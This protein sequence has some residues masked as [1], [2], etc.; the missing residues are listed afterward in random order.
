[1]NKSLTLGAVAALLMAGSQQVAAQ[2]SNFCHLQVVSDIEATPGY[3][4]TLWSPFGTATLSHFSFSSLLTNTDKFW[5]I[6]SSTPVDPGNPEDVVDAG[7]GLTLYS[8]FFGVRFPAG[9][10]PDLFDYQLSISTISD[11]ALPPGLVSASLAMY[12]PGPLHQE[13]GAVTATENFTGNV[14]GSSTLAATV[15]PPDNPFIPFN[16][17]GKDVTTLDGDTTLTVRNSLSTTPGSNLVA[18]SINNQFLGKVHRPSAPE[19]TSLSLFG[20]GLAGLALARRW[21]ARPRSVPPT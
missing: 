6:L 19:P 2:A 21:R 5:V 16:P 4:C 17:Y 20:V 10:V 9:N 11:S 8:P 12:A 1:M 13:T 15:M 14:V 7:F 18:Y 3:S